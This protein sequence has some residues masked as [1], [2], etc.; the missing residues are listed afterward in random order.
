MKKL[1]IATIIGTRPEIIRLQAVISLFDI[2]F[3]QRIIHT[4]Q[5]FDATLSGNFFAELGIRSPDLMLNCSN[6]SLGS[7]LGDLFPKIEKEFAANRPDAILILGDTNS[8]LVSIQERRMGIP[9][10]HLEAGNR[11][12][13]INVPEEINRKVVDHCSD[14]NLCYTEHAR[15][16]LIAEGL[17]PRMISVI[18]SPMKEVISNFIEQ[19]DDSAALKTNNLEVSNYFLVSLH[20]QENVDDPL[21][22]KMLMDSLNAIA[23]QYQLPILVSTHPRTKAKLKLA[24]LHIHKHVKFHEPFGFVDYLNLQKN[25]KAVISDSGSV[26]EESAIL[27]FPA[28]T[29][30]NSIERPEA[31]E[32]GVLILAGLDSNSVLNAIES[33]INGKVASRVPD[34]YLITDTSQRV[35]RFIQSTLPNYHFWTGRRELE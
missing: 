30:R 8:S 2:D 28:I 32:T 6:D 20:R 13:D 24:N 16:N 18:G 4:G 27:G 3:D 1:K 22:L 17:H 34:E 14:F 23:D 10:Y 25:S 35:S 15:R 26:S 11:S 29:T 5:N 21:R 12:F 9:V 7:F 33:I 19:I 31:I